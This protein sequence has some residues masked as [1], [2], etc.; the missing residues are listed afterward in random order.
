MGEKI[1]TSFG[2]AFLDPKDKLYSEIKILGSI[3]AE[4]G[5][6]VCCGGYYGTMEAICNGAI[7]TGGKTIGVTIANRNVKPN[8]YLSEVIEKVNLMDR[9]TA[10]IG[11]A[12]CYLVFKGGTGTL[13]EISA[14]LEMMNKKL[15]PEKKMIFY[16]DFWKNM[17]DT[18]DQD[19]ENLKSLINKNIIF[20]NSPDELKSLI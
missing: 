10:L 9:I 19:S 14:V 8:D 16:S 3:C 2:T 13:L 6:T 20:I 18:L 12:D 17:I 5:Y 11:I 1:I 4:K 15:I 7:T